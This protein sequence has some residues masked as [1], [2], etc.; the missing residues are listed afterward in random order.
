MKEF[1]VSEIAEVKFT[2]EDIWVKVKWEDTVSDVRP[3]TTD[4]IRSF[5]CMQSVINA[6]PVKRYK[7]K[8]EN[9]WIRLT[10]LTN[11]A[12][13]WKSFYQDVI[14]R[15]LTRLCDQGDEILDKKFSIEKE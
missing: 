15:S 14:Y 4:N 2:N 6:R 7:I 11:S 8:W 9:S 5:E 13:L 10:Q 12:V 1:I 3:R